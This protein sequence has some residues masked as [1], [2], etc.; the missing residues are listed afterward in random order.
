[1]T[2]AV[3]VHDV[4]KLDSGQDEHAARGAEIAREYLV[5]AG[6]SGDWIA[7]VCQ[8]I[9]NHPAAL[10]FASDHLPVEDHILRDADFMDEVGAVGIVWTVM[11][12]GIEA[13]AYAEAR[14]RIAKYDRMT[15]E[16]AVAKMT[17]CAG[18]GIAEQRL[19]FIND[20]IAQLD[21][22]FGEGE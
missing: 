1:V 17:T 13:P 10:T 2:I 18:R 4:A 19:E 9:V 22:E 14:A 12:T 8:V 5:R 20:F 11:N 6:F 3:I 16:R 7:R 15:A 21:D